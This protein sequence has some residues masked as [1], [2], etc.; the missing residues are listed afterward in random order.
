M[1]RIGEVSQRLHEVLKVC[2]EVIN[3]SRYPVDIVYGEL[4]FGRYLLIFA[5]FGFSSWISWRRNSEPFCVLHSG[6]TSFSPD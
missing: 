5:D 1:W 3:F 4:E 2:F 6:L